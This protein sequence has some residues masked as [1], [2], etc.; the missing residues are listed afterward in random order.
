MRL[1][2]AGQAVNP[3]PVN[4]AS[5]PLRLTVGRWLG[6]YPAITALL[7]V[8]GPYLLGK[9]PLPLTTL[10]LTA[11]LVPLT[12]YLV[13]PL[14]ERL[15]GGW[16]RF[17]AQHGPAHHRTAIVVWAVTWPLI[18]LVL[19]LVLSLLHGKVPI[20]LL[21]LAVTLTAV[22]LQSLVLLPAVMPRMMGW[23]RGAA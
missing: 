2:H 19:L 11:I 23:I 17:P 9:L 4:P 6:I 8:L 22:P 18:T 16:V 20:P 12:H 21:T 1:R 13:F 10:I 7:L 15:L 14:V 5:S 3:A